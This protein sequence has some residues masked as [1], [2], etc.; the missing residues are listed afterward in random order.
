MIMW[1]WCLYVKRDNST[2][3]EK[4]RI[5][6][7]L[8]QHHDEVK[9]NLEGMGKAILLRSSFSDPVKGGRCPSSTL[10]EI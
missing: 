6:F 2:L 3:F 9:S 7:K 10:K 8:N 5:K 4:K 1:N